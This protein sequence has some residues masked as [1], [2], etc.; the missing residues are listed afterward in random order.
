M[1]V[2]M[3]GRKREVTINEDGRWTMVGWWDGGM[4]YGAT[5]NQTRERPERTGPETRGDLRL[6]THSLALTQQSPDRIGCILAL[7][8]PLASWGVGQPHRLSQAL[9]A[10]KVF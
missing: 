1:P 3:D 5:G 7:L 8:F 9:D 4:G 6:R 2:Q 10:T